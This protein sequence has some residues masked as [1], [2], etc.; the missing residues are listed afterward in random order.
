LQEFAAG[1]LC[2]RRALASFGRAGSALT[3]NPDRTPRWPVGIV[4]SISH[5]TGFCGA[6]VA[7]EAAL[8]TLGLDA[9]ILGRVTDDT[10]PVVFTDG[11]RER[12]AS[13]DA[14]GA[15]RLATIAFSAKEAF[16]KLQ[17]PLTKSWID[18]ADVEI[19]V[20]ESDANGGAFVVR[21][22]REIPPL[23]A[24]LALRGRFRIEESLVVSGMALD[25]LAPRR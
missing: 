2:A 25:P 5:T 13:R 9:E 19:D 23:L 12:L 1:R 20:V 21:P 11:E 6:V 22:V 7:E 4:G 24:G 17:F 14:L 8:R 18:F 16:Y 15:R 3:I 10:W